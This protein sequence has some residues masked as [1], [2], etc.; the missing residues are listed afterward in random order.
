MVIK[1]VFAAEFPFLKWMFL[2]FF[3]PLWP[4]STKFTVKL[5]K[6]SETIWQQNIQTRIFFFLFLKSFSRNTQMPSSVVRCFNWW[7]LMYKSA[8]HFFDIAF[9]YLIHHYI[10]MCS[11]PCRSKS[12]RRTCKKTKEK[13]L[14]RE[15]PDG[16]CRRVCHAIRPFFICVCAA[17]VRVCL[18]EIIGTTTTWTETKETLL[19]NW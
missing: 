7:S 15:K 6:Y 4:T 8:M 2:L 13:L 5:E 10:F 18:I 1:Q 17:C 14:P 3:C 11:S 16:D 9:F 12:I 19:T